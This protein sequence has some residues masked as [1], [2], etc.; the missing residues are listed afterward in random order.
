S[1]QRGGRG[2]GMGGETVIAWLWARTV[3]CPNPA[4]GAQMPLV[5]SF[6]LSKKKGRET[7]VE[8]HVDPHTRQVTFAVRSGRGK[9]PEGT[10]NR[11]GGTCLACG[12]PVPFEHIRAAGKAGRMG[13]Q[14][15]AIV[16]EGE[17]GR[18]Y[19]APSPEHEQI[20]REAEPTW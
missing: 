7:W 20:A 1:A 8:P 4:C 12:S 15:M 6:D 18:N 9:A 11:R 2:Q 16:T 13:A 10:V 5:R 19:Y 14:L 17:R 3:K